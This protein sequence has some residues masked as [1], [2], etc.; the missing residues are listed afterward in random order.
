M[1]VRAPG[2]DPR[3]MRETTIFRAA[4]AVVG[5]FDAALRPDPR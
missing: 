4:L 5:F 3:G 1:A 2:R